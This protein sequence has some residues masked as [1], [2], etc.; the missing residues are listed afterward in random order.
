[1][2]DEKFEQAGA[3]PAK[4]KSY[5]ERSTWLRGVFMVVFAVIWGITEVVLVGVVV[6]QFGFALFTRAPN[7]QLRAFGR[8]LARFLYD[9][10]VFLTYG[11]EEKPWPFAPWPKGTENLPAEA[12]G[13]N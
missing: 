13:K 5:L 7:E 6:L 3:E 11:S 9:I 1:M 4:E 10:T 8:E 2:A 12:S